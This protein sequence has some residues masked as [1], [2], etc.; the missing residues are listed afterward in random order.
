MQS[1]AKLKNLRVAPRKSRLVVDMIRG[2]RVADALVQL[3]HSKKHVAVSVK[4]LLESAVANATHNH[5]MDLSSLVVKVAF[6]DEGKTLYRWMPRAMG[7][8]TPLRKRTSHITL[9]LEGTVSDT[10]AAP[11]KEAAAEAPTAEEAPAAEEKKKAAPKKAKK[12]ASKKPAAKKPT[13][14]KDA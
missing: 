7:R 11:K 5:N 8:A 9:V 10:P 6:V 14:K 3:Q 1:T 4:K 12:A 2:A 13:K